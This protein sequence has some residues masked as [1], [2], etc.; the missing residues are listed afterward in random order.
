MGNSERGIAKHLQI[1]RKTVERKILYL[2]KKAYIKNK[3]FLRARKEKVKQ[4][5]FDETKAKALN[6]LIKEVI[7]MKSIP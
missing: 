1:Y 5:Q 2:A 3:K 6:L 7:K 4:L